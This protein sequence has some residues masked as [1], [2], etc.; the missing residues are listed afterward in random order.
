MK[1]NHLHINVPNVKK[2]QDFYQNFF[3]F[4]VEFEHGDGVF[5][6]DDVG[7]LL[8]IDPLQDNEAV[9]FP[10]WFHFGFCLE[11]AKE[12]KDLY[13]KMKEDGVEFTRDYKEF[14]KDAANFYCRA[15]GSYN[16]EVTWNRD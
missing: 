11:S 4:K 13:E 10:K 16:L 3:N 8:A 7:F 5:L 12:V 14:G 9:D 2:A 15:P 1:L 6:K